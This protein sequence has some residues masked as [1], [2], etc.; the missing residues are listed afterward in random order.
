MPGMSDKMALNTFL[1]H[2]SE[3]KY[4]DTGKHTIGE[5]SKFLPIFL[6]SAEGSKYHGW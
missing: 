1:H 4:V 3:M 2:L 5:A 6:A